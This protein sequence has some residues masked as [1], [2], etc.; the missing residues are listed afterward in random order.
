MDGLKNLDHYRI[1]DKINID[2]MPAADLY[3]WFVKTLALEF[4]PP[5]AT[6]L[7]SDEKARRKVIFETNVKDMKQVNMWVPESWQKDVLNK[8]S[9]CATIGTIA[10]GV[11]PS[12]LVSGFK[13]SAE[14]IADTEKALTQTRRHLFASAADWLGK[15][16]QRHLFTDPKE[17]VDY[18]TF[19]NPVGR[20]IVGGWVHDQLEGQCSNDWILAAHEV[21]SAQVR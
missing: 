10:S 5:V 20:A 16:V 2:T 21:A 1:R 13:P 11:P 17:T 8:Q 4:K 3:E 12:C 6:A 15:A 9:D 18:T 19:E 7:S 14:D